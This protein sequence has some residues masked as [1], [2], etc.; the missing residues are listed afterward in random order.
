MTFS[1]TVDFTANEGGLGLISGGGGTHFFGPPASLLKS[2]FFHANPVAY[3]VAQEFM[4]N[5]T[6]SGTVTIT[7]E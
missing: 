2:D 5:G 3:A 4:S 7:A 1:V 6:T